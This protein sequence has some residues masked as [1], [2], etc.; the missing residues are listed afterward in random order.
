MATERLQVILEMAAGQYKREAKQAAAAT[1]SISKEAKTA[2]TQTGGLQT[3]MA[4]FGS[5]IRGA[6]VTGGVIAFGRGL[7][8]AAEAAEEAASQAAKTEQIIRQTGGAANVSAEDIDQ[9]TKR[10]ASLTG[11]EDD[12]VREG[13]NVLLTF[14]NLKNEAG[15]GNDVFD[16][17]AALMLDVGAVMGTDASSAALQLGKAL[18]DPVS[19]MGA[20]SRAGLTFSQQQK[21][22]I[23]DLVAN[24]DLLGA[25]KLILAELETQVG[26][27]AAA[28]AKATDRLASSFGEIVEVIGGA[29]LPI[30]DDAADGLAIL[31][32]T[33]PQVVDLADAIKEIGEVNLS[34]T[35]QVGE[36]VGLT[37]FRDTMRDIIEAAD[38]TNDELVELA[39]GGMKQL[40]EEYDLTGSRAE[41]LAGVIQEMIREDSIA[42]ANRHRGAIEDSGDAAED[43]AG[44]Y[45]DAGDAVEETGEQT[46]TA[47][48]RV[49]DLTK[50]YLEAANPVFAAQG[51]M[52]RLR[53]AQES[54]DEAQKDTES[55][56]RDVA[57]AELAVAEAALDAEGALRDLG[58]GD[59]NR[60]IGVIADALGKSDEEA[61][62]LLEALGILDG[63]TV[64]SVVD[65]NFQSS[66][67]LVAR[68]AITQGGQVVG[69]R[70]GTVEFRQHGGP[71]F[72]SRPYIVGERGP[73]LFI[74]N[75]SGHVV[76]NHRLAAAGPSGPTI[77]VGTVYGFDDFSAKVRDAGINISRLGG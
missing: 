77:Y 46:K 74:P 52:D 60:A 49:R 36:V 62:L 32:G 54:L 61:R 69:V 18:N 37:N 48:E 39:T 29:L 15:E 59:I 21:D 34:D 31:A 50:A 56:A 58:A 20:L 7:F 26:G 51:A 19:Q 41:V 1:S 71:V 53:S 65:V 17:T 75:T 4:G 66:G 47:A 3:K 63:T 22:Q 8:T 24:N 13:A 28:G 9:L 42:A 76:A 68:R 30:I 10:F 73:E 14:R 45:E 27:T 70:S 2:A 5:L 23:K 72:G 33:S 67:D 6:A 16:R 44:Q 40:Q 38:L 64:T 25:Q 55:T 11:V 35:F 57:D 43:A 12:V